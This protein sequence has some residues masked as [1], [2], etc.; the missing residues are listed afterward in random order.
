MVQMQEDM[1]NTRGNASRGKLGSRLGFLMLAAGC[2]VGL[3]NVWRF[4]FVVG[5]N[6]GAAFVLLYLAFLM[7]FGL[8]LL[9]AELSLGRAS[10]CGISGALRTLARRNKTGWWITGLVIFSGNLLLMLYYSDVGGWLLRFTDSYLRLGSPPGFSE[11]LSEKGSCALFMSI[12]VAAAAVVCAFGVRNGVERI[13][14]WMMISLLV[15]IAVLVVKSLTLEGAPEGLAFYLRPDWGKIA[16]RPLK[17][18]FEAMGQAFFT[19]SVGV[20]CMTIFGSYIDKGDSLVKEG[21][22]IVIIDTVIAVASGLIIFPA[23]ATYGVAVDSGPGLIFEALP[24]V[25]AAMAGGRI[26]GALF[27]LF[28][29]LASLT[30]IIAVFECIIGGLSDE[31]GWRRA[32]VALLTGIVVAVGSLPVIFFPGT[33]E[34]EDFIFSQIYLPLGAFAICFFVSCRSGWG[35]DGFRKEASCGRGVDLPECVKTLFR[36]VIPALIVFIVAGGIAL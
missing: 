7:L 32:P 14:K 10:G 33:L 11:M 1:E 35:F 6:G 26:W 2:A 25:F 20:G 21:A 24:K 30:T 36:W 31:A 5:Q 29:T 16:E 22:V 8:P 13:T 34:I 28:L 12:V 15:L 18:V 27:F 19:L 23:C 17:T 9:I 3:G 4:P